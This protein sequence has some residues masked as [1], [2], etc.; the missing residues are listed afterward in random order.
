M[1]KYFSLLLVAIFGFMVVSCIDRTNEPIKDND[2][3]SVAY[4][5]KG[6]NFTKSSSS[7][8]LYIYSNTF[9]NPLY[10]SDV[11]LIYRQTDT[12]NGSPV[13]QLLPKT[14]YMN[15]GALDYTFDF[16]K[17]DIQIYANSDFDMFIQDATFKNTYLNGQNFRVVIV[18]ASQGKNAGVDYSDYNSVVK[19]FNIDES[20]IKNL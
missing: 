2:T 5:L 12:T 19:F 6:I 8:N 1:K 9:K 7:N 4:D 20:K 17:Y 13:W 15:Q 16:S 11:V 18:P 10:N 3:Y 14:Y